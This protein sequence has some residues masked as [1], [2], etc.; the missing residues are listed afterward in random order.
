MHRFKDFILRRAD[1]A[2]FFLST[3]FDASVSDIG[4]AL[5]SGATL[6]IEDESVLKPGAEFTHLFG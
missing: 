2:L 6:Y 3:N 5:L 1:R 4:T